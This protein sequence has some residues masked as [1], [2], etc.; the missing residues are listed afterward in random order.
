M[1]E[2]GDPAAGAAPAPPEVPELEADR[3]LA[4]GAFIREQRG[5]S[6]LSMRRLADLS[7]VSNP[8]LSQIERGLRKPSAD[9]LRQ[10]AGAL[11]VS[12][13][14]LYVR[15][16][17]LPDRRAGVDVVSEIL[18]DPHLRPAHRQA[19]VTAYRAFRAEVGA[20]LPDP[21]ERASEDDGEESGRTGR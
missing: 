5:R 7:G 1:D 20:P 10:L 2:A 15:A 18:R 13:E 6:R 8:Y 17:M 12:T 16:G 14:A 11:E 9:I 19:L 4:L 21:D 3:L